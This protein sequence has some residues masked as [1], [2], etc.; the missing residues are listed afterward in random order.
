MRK[1]SH[2]VVVYFNDEELTDLTEKVR[3]TRL[4]REEIIRKAVKGLV[5]KEVPPADIPFLIRELRRVGHNLNQLAVLAH[6]KGVLDTPQ[7][8]RALERKR[9][10][11]KLIV[12][13]YTRGGG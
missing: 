2:R 12:D 11:E 7:L 8:R 10:V 6:S 3:Q 9:A 5:V 1:R 4:P 13:A